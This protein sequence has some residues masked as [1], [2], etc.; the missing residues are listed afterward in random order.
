MADNGTIWGNTA[1]LEGKERV[2]YHRSLY[3]RSER[4]R[5]ARINHSRRQRG[6][7]EIASLAETTLRIP[8]DRR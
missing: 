6:A 4:H 3:Q 2:A 7:P 5:L 1:M 8:L